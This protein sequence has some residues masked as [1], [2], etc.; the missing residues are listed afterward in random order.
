MC[1]GWQTT[2]IRFYSSF[3]TRSGHCAVTILNFPDHR[4]HPRHS[5]PREE[6]AAGF[7]TSAIHYFATASQYTSKNTERLPAP[8][9]LSELYPL[10]EDIR[11][12]ARRY[13]VAMASAS[14]ASMSMSWKTPRR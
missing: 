3:Y 9:P 14:K 8:L 6:L 7:L 12:F 5:T 11:A 2:A 13:Y 1:C 4:S 10:L